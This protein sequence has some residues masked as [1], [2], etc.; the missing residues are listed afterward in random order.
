MGGLRA[1]EAPLCWLTLAALCPQHG[2]DED[3]LAW[4][5]A[6]RQGR[7]ETAVRRVRPVGSGLSRG[8]VTGPSSPLPVGTGAP[9]P[10]RG[11]WAVGR[12]ELTRPE[13]V[14]YGQLSLSDG[15]L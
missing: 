4:Q 7:E 8:P 11:I 3:G 10:V 12:G 2:R 5:L 14:W 6:Q 15:C 1:L 9:R 13:R